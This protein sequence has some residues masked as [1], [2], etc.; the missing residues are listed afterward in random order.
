MYLK[1]LVVKGFKTFAEKEE[2]TFEAKTGITAIVGP[3]GCGKSNIVDSFR[4]ALGESNLRGLRVHSLPEVIFAGTL[5]KKSLSLAEVALIFDNSDHSLPIDYSEVSVKRRTFRDGESEFLINNQSSRLKDIRDL[6]L[7][8][9]ISNES[10]SV[11]SQGNVDAVLSSKPEER[12]AIFEEVAGINKYKFRKMEAERKLI[13]SEQNL[14]RISDLKVEVGEQLISLESQ[15]A[16]AKE[17]VGIQAQLRAIELSTFKKQARL[18]LDK[19]DIVVAELEE[20]KR[21]SKEKEDQHKKLLEDRAS[22]LAQL[23]HVESQIEQAVRPN[24]GRARKPD[25]GKRKA[26]VRTEGQLAGHERGAAVC[27]V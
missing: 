16:S 21:I 9:G 11:M 5:S 4:F 1:S 13:L 6:F 7:D 8:S 23:R 22:H 26:P 3:N 27:A 17:Y 25:L 15:A 14:L 18:L 24:R 19:K 12:R 20:Y 10:I 2:L